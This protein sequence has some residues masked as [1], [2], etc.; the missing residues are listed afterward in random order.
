[1]TDLT[2]RAFL[3]CATAIWSASPD[4]SLKVANGQVVA[5]LGSN[6]AGKTTTLQCHRGLL[7]P[8]AGRIRVVR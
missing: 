2:V 3:K 6:G 1:M 4:I 8:A 7:P 5:L